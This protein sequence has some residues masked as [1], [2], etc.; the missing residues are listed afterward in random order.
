MDKL[1]MQTADGVEDN[2]RKIAMLF[3]DCVTEALEGG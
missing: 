2:I 1:R 3:P